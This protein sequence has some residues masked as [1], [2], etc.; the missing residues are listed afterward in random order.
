MRPGQEANHS[1]Q[2]LQAHDKD[3]SRDSIIDVSEDTK[4]QTVEGTQDIRQT[5]PDTCAGV[6]RN[7]PVNWPAAVARKEWERFD[8]DVYE[9]LETDLAG[10]VGKKLKAMASII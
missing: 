6:V 10:D 7:E 5:G 3:G 2:N 8:H 1:P 4:H 9:V